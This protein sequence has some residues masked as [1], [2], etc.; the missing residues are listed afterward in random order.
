MR[1][2]VTFACLLIAFVTTLQCYGQLTS[3]P[4]KVGF[5]V[6]TVPYFNADI[7]A[8][9]IRIVLNIWY[10][11][12]KAVGSPLPLLDFVHIHKSLDKSVVYDSV[13]RQE[14][15]NLKRFIH[16]NF[17]VADEEAWKELENVKAWSYL[18]AP[19]SSKKF[20]LILGRLRA[21]STTFTNEFLA[22]HGFVVCM[23]N[24]VENHAPEKRALYNRQVINEIE[25]YR[26]VK[27]Y[28]NTDLKI[29]SGRAGLLGFSGG[30]FSQ[31]FLPMKY[32]DFDAVALLESGI[33]LDGDLY[34][35]VSHHPYYLPEH[36]KTPLLF[37]YNKH[38]F[39]QNKASANFQ[40]LASKQNYL[41][42]FDDT[43][44]HHWDFATEGI[45]AAMYL[46]NRD[47]RVGDKQIA[48][49]VT[50]NTHLLQFFNV[51]LNKKGQFRIRP[52]ETFVI[53]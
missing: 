2:L 30:G 6:T 27:E 45:M 12:D 16:R 22:S 26:Y 36:F 23:I 3:G 8:D 33:F 18:N 46:K 37:I 10:P 48:N 39:E 32:P 53:R 25:F 47:K 49:F 21:F 7:S 28:L 44:Q 38:R 52:N 40:K 24:G 31:F 43:T 41:V 19:F 11:T 17:G 29:F 34:D 15:A 35:I 42:L 13:I 5:R 1:K 9:T 51:Y 20:P 50:L 14:K 4:H